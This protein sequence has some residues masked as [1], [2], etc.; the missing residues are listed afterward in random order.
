[1]WPK[2]YYNGDTEDVN[3]PLRCIMKD[4]DG[5]RRIYFENM[6]R[7]MARV[8]SV[9]ATVMTDNPKNIPQTGIWGRVEQVELQAARDRNQVNYVREMVTILSYP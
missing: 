1:M 6:S 3:N 2:R 4:K 9:F 5:N 7:A 8:C